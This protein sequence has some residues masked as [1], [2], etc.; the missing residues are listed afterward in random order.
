MTLE[1]VVGYCRAEKRVCPVP[2]RWN[3]LY[4]ILPDKVRKDSGW[5]PPLP[6]ILAA[7]WEASD[8][9]KR[10]RLEEHLRWAAEHGSLDQIAG[11]VCSLSESEWHHVGD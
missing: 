1:E 6:L 4:E 8:Q 7:W 2:Q 5:E 10:V 11:F 9:A 3:D